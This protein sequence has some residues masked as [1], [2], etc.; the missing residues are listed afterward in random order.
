MDK[1]LKNADI[2]LWQHLKIQVFLS[3]VASTMLNANSADFDNAFI[4]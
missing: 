3:V 4:C 2:G 1:D